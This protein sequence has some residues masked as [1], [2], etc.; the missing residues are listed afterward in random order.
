MAALLMK[1]ADG[2]HAAYYRRRMKNKRD[3]GARF[4]EQF[5]PWEVRDM[6]IEKAGA[7]L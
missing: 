5:G 2:C 7:L 4:G 3:S 6:R 1:S